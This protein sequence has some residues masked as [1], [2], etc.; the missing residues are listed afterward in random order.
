V[1]SE[2]FVRLM[3]CPEDRTP[4]TQADAALIACLNESIRA[5]RLKNRGGLPVS[6]R[7]DGALVREDQA[8]AY[9]IVQDLPILVVDE[10]IPLEQI[11]RWGLGT[12]G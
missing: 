3:C 4:L 12:R 6:D 7:L 8:I 5:G 2:E 1:L 9:P 11:R 10:G